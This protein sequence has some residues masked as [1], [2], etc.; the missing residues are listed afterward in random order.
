MLSIA[1]TAQ[2]RLARL[3]A[4]AE[5][6]SEP[7]RT[8]LRARLALREAAGWLAHH[9]A[10]V[11]PVDLAFREAGLTGSYTAATLGARLPSVLPVT[12][13]SGGE[14]ASPDDRDVVTA[15]RHARHWRQLA[16]LRRWAPEDLPPLPEPDGTPALLAAARILAGG[17]GTRLS[18][19]E[20]LRAAWLWRERGG[21]GDP[22]LPIWSGP[23][24][25]L[26]RAAL[27]ADPVPALLE[28]IAEAAQAAR[29]ELAR[30]RAAEERLRAIGGTARSRLPAAGEAALRL[31]VL[32]ARALA[33]A[34]GV[35]PRAA[36]SLIARMAAAG[37]LREATGRRAWRGFV[38]I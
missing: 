16:E 14:L 9:G 5:A 7:V 35:T 38:I 6:A 32:T 13:A 27:A 23:V 36:A 26:H 37:V 2:D 28:A 17:G 22:G 11:H 31:P 1:L 24:R 33:A 20:A 3:E 18:A 25:Q 19:S 30:L 12:A 34:L 21:T 10:W 8:G 4:G 15:L 29:R